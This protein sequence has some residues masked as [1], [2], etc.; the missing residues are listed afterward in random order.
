MKINPICNKHT[1]TKFINKVHTSHIPLVNTSN[2]VIN[3][4]KGLA[5]LGTSLLCTTA[6]ENE[7]DIDDMK[8]LEQ[9]PKFDNPMKHINGYIDKTNYMMQ[10]IDILPQD[11][12]IT[13]IKQI[14]AIQ[15]NGNTITLIPEKNDDK[16]L[17]IKYILTKP[18]GEEEITSMTIF[19]NKNYADTKARINKKGEIN[20]QYISYTQ[21][22]AYPNSLYINNITT[23]HNASSIVKKYIIKRTSNGIIN[24]NQDN[25]KE[26]IKINVAL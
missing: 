7:P 5:I 10:L 23:P 2:K 19:D 4:L 22:S 17:Q 26:F 1:T 15:E 3:T 6:C 25:S 20:Y 21:S 9:C 18:S 8:Y 14:E 11:K 12:S 13:D 24:I 16:Q